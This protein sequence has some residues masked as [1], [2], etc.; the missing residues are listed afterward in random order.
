MIGFQCFIYMCL[1]Q[2]E[3]TNPPDFEKKPHFAWEDVYQRHS[4]THLMSSWC[5]AEPRLE[6]QCPHL[7][8]WRK[9]TMWQVEFYSRIGNPG[10]WM[11]ISLTL[12]VFNPW[13][14]HGFPTL[15]AQVPHSPMESSITRTKL[16]TK[17]IKTFTKVQGMEP[18]A[19]GL[20]KHE[21]WS[22]LGQALGLALGSACSTLR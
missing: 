5:S 22:T 17:G 19:S 18:L 14:A 15:N 16:D 21:P 6:C 4:S 11:F 2:S 7:P 8:L 20:N 9:R 12:C 13:A 10:T 3:G 1:G